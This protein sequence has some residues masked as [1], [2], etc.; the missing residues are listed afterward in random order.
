MNYVWSLISSRAGR[1]VLSIVTLG[2]VT[3]AA[4]NFDRRSE[5]KRA[6][7]FAASHAGSLPTTLAE[8]A[9]YPQA[10]RKAITRALPLAEQSR[11]WREQL[12]LVS[13]D[14]S[15]TN[16]QRTFVEKVITMATPESFDP[17]MPTPE[18]CPEV[19]ALFADPALRARVVDLG[20]VATPQRTLWSTVAHASTKLHQAVA[21]HAAT[22]CDCRGLGFCECGLTEACI[23]GCEETNNCG[24][25]W[26]GPCDKHCEVTLLFRAG[27]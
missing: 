7:D 20:S 11:L 10:Y 26:A 8:L 21:L 5:S 24:C 13:Q 14:P 2:V 25:I 3:V 22:Q 17:S 12:T 23:Y 27:K 18:V 19:A 4:V 16:E 6:E 1:V 15:L 9:A